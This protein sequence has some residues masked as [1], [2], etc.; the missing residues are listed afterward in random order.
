VTF[1][2]IYKN[3]LGDNPNNAITFAG[4]L[5]ATAAL[6]MTWI[7]EPPI[8]RDVDAVLEMPVGAH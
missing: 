8:V 4:A 1:G 5:L 6:A 2:V 7:H 3:L